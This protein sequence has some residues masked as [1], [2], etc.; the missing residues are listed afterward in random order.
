MRTEAKRFF[1]NK[2]NQH[3]L[4]PNTAAL[5]PNVHRELFSQ[6]IFTVAVTGKLSSHVVLTISTSK[7]LASPTTRSS[8]KYFMVSL[9]RVLALSM[10]KIFRTNCCIRDMVVRRAGDEKFLNCVYRLSVE[11]TITWEI[12][13]R[14]GI[15]I[16]L[17]EAGRNTNFSQF[18]G[19]RSVKN[20]PLDW[21][22]YFSG[23]SCCCTVSI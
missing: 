11:C 1:H 16:R 4:V 21:K 14:P 22:I 20:I 7:A 6:R 19:G 10:A 18:F 2:K 17:L 23:A 15:Q 5:V 8:I 12:S 13:E 9:A 3:L